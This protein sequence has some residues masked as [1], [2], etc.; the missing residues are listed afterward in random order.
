MTPI[1]STAS[2]A[3]T[4]RPDRH[5]HP[6]AGP[7]PRVALVGA[8]G[9]GARHLD[10]LARLGALNLVELV[11]VADPRPP[12]KGT[13]P[14][15]VATF[16]SLA[17]L[18]AAGP[19]PDVVILATPIQ[20]HAP[21]ALAAIA[22][23]ADVYV[24]KPPM[25][26][27]AQF[28]AVLTAAGA[29]GRLV[30]VGF[31]SLGSHA[32][33]ALDRLVASGG[34]GEVRGVSAVGTWVRTRGYFNRSRWAGKRS[35]D[36]TDVVDGVATN[37]LAHAV[38]TGLRIAGAALASDVVSVETDLYRAHATESDDTSVIRVRTAGGA[39]LLCALT[40]CAEEQTAP[41]V[42]VH[43]TL[44]AAEFFY[45]EDRLTITGPDCERTEMFGR[46]DL[47]EDLLA[48][49]RSPEGVARKLLSPLAGNGA[50]MKVLEA[51]RTAE[52]P[53]AITP[54]HVR[55]DGE[56]DDAHPVVHGI[57][58]L[59]RRA[60]AAQATFAELGVPWAREL[61]APGESSF[62]VNGKVVAVPSDGSRIPPTSSPR[63]YLHP[64]RTLAGT[65]VTEHLP[66]DHVWHL[67][68]GV[69]IQ[70]VN[71]VNFWG[72]RTYTRDAGAYLWRKDH[73]R[74]V[75]VAAD[76]A[77]TADTANEAGQGGGSRTETL[78]WVAP[79]GIPLLSERRTWTW[80]AVTASAWRLTLD[81]ELTPSGP[82]PVALG[83]PGSNGRP[84][85]GYGGFFW[86]LPA[87][88]GATAW[89]ATANGEDAV[90]GAVP[91]Q[92]APWLAW[93]G[94]FRGAGTVSDKEPDGDPATLV[95]LPGPLPQQPG[96]P[97]FVRMAGYPG[98]GLSLA[99]EKA[100]TASHDKP[101]HRSVTVLVADGL[102]ATSDIQQ[103]ITTLG[104]ST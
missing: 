73:G 3:A 13:L 15:G 80:A 29:G 55:W 95:F 62:E 89:T 70:D 65:M 69:A 14:D 23:G 49:R 97:W 46:T 11:S 45:T 57:G 77:D 44:G 8:H 83:S 99:W 54:Q 2:P 94:M 16:Q 74:I 58:P 9:Y 26:S 92:A 39:V 79:G 35:L 100:A 64:V 34:I 31:Q 12:A 37:A 18:L 103:L 19:A 21:L 32:L 27:L 90:H 4:V 88:D 93:S 7:P 104:E 51:I 42:T 30:Q 40:L 87:V 53:R 6:V 72:G 48:V 10:N 24:E 68:A 56:G 52:Q 101:L 61:P 33:P 22:A 17:D 98:V 20:T 41:S 5:E 86:R 28:D 84:Q 25:A 91:S 102:L 59:V 75:T 38:A 67:G 71:G 85:G 50:F 78:S 81:F 47:L 66:D 96:D 1:S 60:A 63:P 76:T 36:G 82:D 43:G